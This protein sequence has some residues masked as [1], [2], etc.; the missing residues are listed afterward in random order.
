LKN[1]EKKGISRRAAEEAL[2]TDPRDLEL[3]T[4]LKKL[5]QHSTAEAFP[6]QVIPNSAAAEKTMAGA[7][8]SDTQGSLASEANREE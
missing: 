8:I 2:A 6:E 3:G 5:L 7:L 4:D 1:L